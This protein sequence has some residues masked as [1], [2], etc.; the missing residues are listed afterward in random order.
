MKRPTGERHRL[1]DIHVLPINDVVE[2]EESED[3]PCEPR[4]EGDGPRFIIIH[5]AFDRREFTECRT[6]KGH[7]MKRFLL[8]GALLL[9]AFAVWAPSCNM[10]PVVE[11]QALP[12]TK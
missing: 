5:H 7:H 12:V 1:A 4:I 8:T 10:L 11:A 2:H 9:S 6:K 3:C